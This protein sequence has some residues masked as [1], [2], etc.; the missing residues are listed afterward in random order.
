MPVTGVTFDDAQ[1][2]GR[3]SKKRLP[4]EMEWE[5]AARGPDGRTWPWGEQAEP[6][7]ANVSEAQHGG[8]E[9]VGSHPD[10]ASYYGCLDMAGN[11]AEWAGRVLGDGRTLD[12]LVKGGGFGDALVEARSAFYVDALGANESHPG[13]GF[14]LARDLER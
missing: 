10:G 7:R 3:W 5:K 1:A 14:R 8:V 13:V 9:K 6:A 4:T 11:V 2:F 12:P